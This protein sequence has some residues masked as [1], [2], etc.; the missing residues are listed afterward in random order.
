MSSPSD[1]PGSQHRLTSQ[2]IELLAAYRQAPSDRN[3]EQLKAFHDVSPAHADALARAEQFLQ[4]SGQLKTRRRSTPQTVW[5]YLELWALRLV[6]HHS[7]LP[8]TVAS[9]FA[10]LIVWNLATPQQDVSL[11]NRQPG[12]SDAQPTHFETAWREQRSITL[13]DGSTVWLG[14]RTELDVDFSAARRTVRLHK[15]VAAFQVRSDP[16]RPFFVRARAVQTRVTGTEFVVDLQQ[17]DK[18]AVSVVEG[19]VSVSGADLS[20]VMLGAEESVA[21]VNGLLATKEFRPQN[22]IGQWRDGM[23]VFEDE[24]L[25]DVL[26]ALQPYTRYQL[27]TSAISGHGGRVTGVFFIEQADEALF[28]LLETHRID[29]DESDSN[30]LFLRYDLTSLL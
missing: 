2:A 15:G 19:Q 10:L 7:A 26:G 20:E 27:N 14:W 9:C 11:A 5:F 29:V 24:A 6:G 8:I 3:R 1:L 17:S 25:L 13:G 21:V 30:R 16:D 22:Q 18:V 28:T 12:A 4:L 23:L